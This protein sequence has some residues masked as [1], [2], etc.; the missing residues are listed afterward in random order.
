MFKKIK[1]NVLELC[2][3]YFPVTMLKFFFKKMFG[4]KLDLNNP[5]IYSEKI[6]WLKF[7]YTNDK[8]AILSGDK[9]G[10]HQYLE[11]KDLQF[12]LVPLIGIYDSVQEIEWDKLPTK[13]V[14]KKSN[15]SGMNLIVSNKKEMDKK[16]ALNTIDEWMKKE[17]GVIGA[18]KHYEKMIPKIVIE[19]YMEGISTDSK[20]LF[21]NGIP[22][23]L[24]INHWLDEDK[25]NYSGHRATI[26]TFTDMNGRIRC[27]A[28]DEGVKFKDIPVEFHEGNYIS[29]PK[30]FEIMVESGKKIAKDFPLVRVDY[31]HS[32]EKLYI[33]ELTFT[34]GSGFEP[35]NEDLQI[36]LGSL[37]SLPKGEK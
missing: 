12:L 23:L 11:E 5:T 26:R 35:L 28:P 32:N 9:A 4:K 16:L 37:L 8:L 22:R 2:Y 13:F 31:F 29:L 6:Q 20:I 30:D 19:D 15:S 3:Q 10:L 25:E 33:G 17:F 7:Y 1:I 21:L 24:Q 36:E 14:I 18:E 34:P 27:V